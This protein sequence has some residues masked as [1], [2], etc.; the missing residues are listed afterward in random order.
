[1][2]SRK[3]LFLIGGLL[4]IAINFA[5]LTMSSRESVDENGIERVAITLVAPFQMD[6][7]KS[8][9]AIEDVWIAYFCVVSAAKENVDFKK[10]L[11]NIDRIKS[12]ARELEF[13]NN[14]LKKLV[15]FTRS[16]EYS[17]VAAKVIA[18]DPSPWFKTIMVDKGKKDGLSKGLPVVVSEGVV[19]HVIKVAPNYARILLITDRNSAVDSLVQNSRVRGI[20]KGGSGKEC[21][22]RYALRKDKI[23]TGEIIISSGFDQI[24]PKGLKV[25]EVVN[26]KKEPSQLFQKIIIKTCVDFDKI[27]EVLVVITDNNR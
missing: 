8:I 5:V 9:K 19:G 16:V 2:F 4:L 27:E 1:M 22:F 21:F 11:A 18:R 15:N 6:V 26:V 14:R 17:F 23:Q 13:E 7:S 3:M 24:F 25:G 10:Q 20:V 12:R